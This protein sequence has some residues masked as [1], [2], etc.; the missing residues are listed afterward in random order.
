MPSPHRRTQDDLIQVEY[1][2]YSDMLRER[3]LKNREDPDL[4]A[5]EILGVDS[6][7]ELAGF[8]ETVPITD[9]QAV[10]VVLAELIAT[11]PPERIRGANPTRPPTWD[12]VD[13]GD[14]AIRVP[15]SISAFLDTGEGVEAPVWF[16]TW[17]QNSGY[18]QYLH[19][20]AHTQHA[21]RIEG[22]L[23][24]LVSSARSDKSPYRHRVVESQVG[25]GGM[26][27]RVVPTPT[28]TRAALIFEDDVWSAVTRN[29]DR[30]FERM[31]VLRESGL[32]GNRGLLL[33]GPPGTGKT[34]LCRALAAEYEGRATVVIVSAAVGSYM[35]GDLYERLDALSP[36]L[37]LVEDLDLIVGSREEGAGP[38]LIQFLTVLD[39]LMTRHS[40]V[41][42]IATTNDPSA[43]DA[44][45]TR[46]ARF[47][48]VVYLGLP[49]EEA[50]R[51]IVELYLSRVNHDADLDD[52][53][54]RSD[55]L[56]GADLREVVRSAVLDSDN[57][58]LTP[59]DLSQALRRMLSAKSGE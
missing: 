10:L 43:I 48:Q 38:G 45:A 3:R 47:D 36:A 30:M 27:L 40:G 58:T 35:L 54:A 11:I 1:E 46:A 59:D 49:S 18:S 8:N 32:G 28:E 13:V 33:A 16:R 39:G 5:C 22:F 12:T 6:S 7:D 55:G 23:P 15:S 31:D 29:V 37:V 53:A 17:P 52:L 57:D 9:L 4:A 51:A 19:V 50:R 2:L 56:S 20:Y 44:A 24:G 34:A 14:R 41:V 25:P 42:T 21:E 26:T